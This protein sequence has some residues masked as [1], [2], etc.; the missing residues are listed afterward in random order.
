MS[1]TRWS[2]GNWYI[3][4]SAMAPG[5]VIAGKKE[6]RKDQCLATWLAG[7]AHHPTNTYETIKKMYESDD[8]SGLGYK[9]LYEKE[10]LVS[11]VKK[12]LEEVEAEFKE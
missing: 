11:C 1:Y 9:E 7:E 12:W 4:W 10:T 2:D 6:T 8:W 3:F 5:T